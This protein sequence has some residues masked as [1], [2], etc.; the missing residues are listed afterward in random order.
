MTAAP[1]FPEE[2]SKFRRPLSLEGLRCAR[3]S[4][5]RDVEADERFSYSLWALEITLPGFADESQKMEE[6]NMWDVIQCMQISYIETVSGDSGLN[7]RSPR[8][9]STREFL[10][11]HLEE[12]GSMLLNLALFSPLSVERMS[13]SLHGMAWHNTGSK[14]DP[15]KAWDHSRGKATIMQDEKWKGDFLLPFTLSFRERMGRGTKRAYKIRI[16]C[17]MCMRTKSCLVHRV[18]AGFIRISYFLIRLTAPFGRGFI[19]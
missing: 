10:R 9:R 6:Q 14:T 2:H 5:E 1:L 16:K 19:S 17:K 15:W 12:R 18:T 13:S 3:V 8:N 7:S 11:P 4:K